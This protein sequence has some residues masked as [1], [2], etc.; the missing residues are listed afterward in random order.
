MEVI[1]FIQQFS[2]PFLD[3]FFSIVTN[4][5]GQTIGIITSLILFWCIDNFLFHLII[6]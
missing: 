2:N 6:Y 4:L 1:K 3:V 5:G